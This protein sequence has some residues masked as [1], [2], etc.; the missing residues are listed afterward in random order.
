MKIG[1]TLRVMGPQSTAEILGDCARAAEELGFDDI[2][3]V[4]HI[5]IPP[6]DAEG[7]DG[8]YLDP[9]AALGWLAGR[10]ERIGLGTAILNL[11]YRPPLP[12]AKAIATIQELSGGRLRLGV[13]VG[14]MEPEFRALGVDRRRRGAQTDETLAFLHHCFEN[15]VATANGQSFLFRP[16]PERPPIYVGGAGPHALRRAVRYGEG[17]LPMVSD[18][19][20]LAEP[21]ETLRKLAAEAGRPRPEV[22]ALTGLPGDPER[23]QERLERLEELGVTHLIA[24]T[25]YDT[26]DEFRR[27]AEAIARVSLGSPL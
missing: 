4:D 20:K 23:A 14:W 24:G 16:R 27:Q 18:P 3:V 21:I 13:G 2:W 11:P 17:W 5:A 1:V 22:V 19:E 9:L 26:A 10:T 12:T 8:R 6:D 15:D 25:R 7:S